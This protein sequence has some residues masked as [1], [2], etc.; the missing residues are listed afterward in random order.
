MYQ[1]I[2]IISESYY[3]WLKLLVPK[4]PQ[5]EKTFALPAAFIQVSPITLMTLAGQHYKMEEIPW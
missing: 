5:D 3:I 2:F 4:I 1:V